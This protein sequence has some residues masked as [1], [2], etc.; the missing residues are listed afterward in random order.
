MYILSN[1]AIQ[2]RDQPHGKDYRGRKVFRNGGFNSDYQYGVGV[3]V[4]MPWSSLQLIEPY[5]HLHL[6]F[7][8]LPF[9]LQCKVVMPGPTNAL[10]CTGIAPVTLLSKSAPGYRPAQRKNHTTVLNTAK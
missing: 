5:W 7:T 4:S 2:G 9:D 10:L 3:G 8:P 6:C 1:L